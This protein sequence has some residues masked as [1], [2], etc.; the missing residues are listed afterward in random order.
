MQIDSVVGVLDDEDDVPFNVHL[1]SVAWPISQIIRP[2]V[3]A[4]E[5]RENVQSDIIR[6]DEEAWMREEDV[7]ARERHDRETLVRVSKEESRREMR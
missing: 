7:E 4:D 3:A 1:S 6:E 2:S 5:M